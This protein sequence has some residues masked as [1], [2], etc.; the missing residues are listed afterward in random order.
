MRVL[1]LSLGMMLWA[2]GG[3]GSPMPD[4][5]H[6][7]DAGPQVPDAGSPWDAVG[8]LLESRAADAGM[9]VPGLGLAVYDSQDRKVYER[10]VGDFA[11]D[12]RVA[13]ASASK[14]VAGTVLFE[15]I[16]QG[17]LSL[18]STTGQVLGWSGDKAGITL[19]HLLSFT[20]GLQHEHGCTLQAGSTLADC[21]ATLATT[22]PVAPPGTRY[23]Y[24]STH[25]HV[26]ARMA[27]V[28]TGRSWNALFT[29]TL[30]A[31]L[32][33][34]AEV[35]YF[36]FPR[37]A[38]GTTNPLIA[39]G[40]RT[41][42]NEYARLLAL[43]FHRGRYAGLERGTP[44][45]FDAQ[46]REPFPEVTVGNSPV[47]DLGLGYRYGLTA[48]LHCDTPAQ[49]CD[50]ISSPGA[51]GWTPWVDREAGYYAIL[52]MQLDRQGEGVVGFSV[53]LSTELQPLIRA[54]LAR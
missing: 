49:G 24:G 42:M 44:E 14:L 32:G 38:Q 5:G 54:A 23:D 37:Q 7:S 8:A 36:T 29:E 48:W 40:L 39:G 13:V 21:V 20:S 1:V 16:R 46:T 2:C 6:T 17:H 28:A 30:A 11:P 50:V 35:R 53:R 27:E 9:T 18:D 31:P 22:Q 52:G 25:L 15:V 12:R 51:F 19:R 47:K 41:S 33:L 45:L 3:G 26:A 4:G 43:V 34:P 10:M